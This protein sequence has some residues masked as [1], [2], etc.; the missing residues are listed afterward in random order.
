M[1]PIPPDIAQRVQQKVEMRLYPS[2]HEVLRHA[3]DALDAHQEQDRQKVLQGRVEAERG[4]VTL[5]DMADIIRE[6][7]TPWETQQH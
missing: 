2:P 5:L 4:D 7:R 3:L 6:A 1:Q